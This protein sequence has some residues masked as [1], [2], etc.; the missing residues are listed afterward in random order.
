MT[1]GDNPVSLQC[2]SVLGNTHQIRPN[3]QSQHVRKDTPFHTPRP[4]VQASHS[5]PPVTRRKDHCFS[6]RH[7]GSTG[8]TINHTTR[9]ADPGHEQ[10][11]LLTAKEV[12]RHARLNDQHSH[13]AREKQG[14]CSQSGNNPINRHVS[15]TRLRSVRHKGTQDLEVCALPLCCAWVCCLQRN[16]GLARCATASRSCRT[17]LCLFEKKS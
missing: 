8:S 12:H 17:W 1:L 6:A 5:T 15:N 3:V 7:L 11:S 2:R 16:T 10:P 14:R 13:L 4:K 9:P